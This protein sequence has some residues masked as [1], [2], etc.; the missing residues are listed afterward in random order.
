MAHICDPTKGDVLFVN[1]LSS[2]DPRD[3]FG[4]ATERGFVAAVIVMGILE[5]KAIREFDT[6]KTMNA[7]GY[8]KTSKYEAMEALLKEMATGP[9][10]YLSEWQDEI[11][12]VL[13]AV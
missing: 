11:K 9:G 8:F 13:A 1:S 5:H 4:F 6:E 7:F 3:S 2:C 12:K 10:S